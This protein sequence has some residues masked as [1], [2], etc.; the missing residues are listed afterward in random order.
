[1]RPDT[2]ERRPLG[3]S[4]VHDPDEEVTTSV[5]ATSDIVPER[6]WCRFAAIWCRCGLSPETSTM[7]VCA[8]HFLHEVA[9]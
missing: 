2:E 1:M 9:G 6:R 4:G 7:S 3:E 8:S 5:A